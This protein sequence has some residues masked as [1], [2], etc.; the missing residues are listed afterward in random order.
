MNKM[1]T[2]F[3]GARVTGLDNEIRDCSSTSLSDEN[4]KRMDAMPTTKY[5]FLRLVYFRVFLFYARQCSKNRSVNGRR[6]LLAIFVF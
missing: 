1:Y 6:K 4:A 2:L 5:V 3:F